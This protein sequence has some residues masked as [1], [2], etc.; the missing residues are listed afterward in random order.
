VEAR[1]EAIREG[2]NQ[3]V[4]IDR[5]T[6]I[7]STD[8]IRTLVLGDPGISV[9]DLIEHTLVEDDLLNSSV[10]Q[11]MWS[12]LRESPVETRRHF[13]NFVTGH[14]RLPLDGMAALPRR[15]NIAVSADLNV[16][17]DRALF[18]L[19]IPMYTNPIELA[20]LLRHAV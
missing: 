14:W 12:W 3:V 20:S 6:A 9:D 17:A 7:A 18:L 5:L 11:W 4:P 16:R 10:I 1:F 13:L 8:D 2:F 15:M 19:E